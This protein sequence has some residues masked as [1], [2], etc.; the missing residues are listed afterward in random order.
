MT[1]HYARQ[2]AD[3]LADMISI[4]TNKGYVVLDHWFECDQPDHLEDGVND[5]GYNVILYRDGKE[6]RR[7]RSI[8][9]DIRNRVPKTYKKIWS[10]DPNLYKTITEDE[11]LNGYIKHLTAVMHSD[12]LDMSLRDAKTMA[13]WLDTEI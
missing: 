5:D 10:L 1:K 11:A 4:P 12:L 3:L 8:D 2:R 7:V 6:W 9:L 13:E